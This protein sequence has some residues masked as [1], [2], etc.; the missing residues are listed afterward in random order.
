[1]ELKLYNT[2]TQKKECFKPIDPKHIRIYACG[3][4]VYNFAHIGNARMAIVFDVLTRILNIAY[5]KVSYV[6]NITD[7]DDKIIEKAN[8]TGK[9]IQNITTHYT[10]M[11]NQNMAAL[12]VKAPTHQPKATD[13]IPEM[14][15]FIQKLILA[16]HAYEAEGHVLF[17]V[18]S[19]LHYGQLSGRN[20]DEQ[21][22]GSRVDIAPFKKDPAD[23][24]LWKP[25]TENQPGWPSPWGFGRPGWHTEC[26]AMS[27]SC[28]GFPFDIH[29]GGQD[30]CFPHHENEIAQ[31]CC[32]IDSTQTAKSMA[33]IWIH[34][35]FVT[36]KESKMSKSL[37]NVTLVDEL[38]KKHHGETVRL[39][40]LLSHYRQPLNWTDQSLIQAKSILDR[41]Y[42]AILDMPKN[43]ILT[44]NKVPKACL[45]ALF[46]DINTAKFFAY[47]HELA[48]KI[49]QTKGSEKQ[50]YQGGLL[51]AANLI[52]VLHQEPKVW[53]GY[54]SN[55]KVNE[56]SS[57][58]IEDLIQKRGNAKKQKDYPTADA[59][60]KHLQDLGIELEDSPEGTRWRIL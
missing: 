15:Q 31:S 12:G 37:G 43:L 40:L 57:K 41:F 45:D 44:Q 35:G 26:C 25:S 47:L 13:Y 9:S 48:G 58:E 49:Q 55:L 21:I 54:K 53:L 33:N 36:I 27:L 60:R 28:L 16:D 19:Y 7:I 59:I 39:A 6:S 38:L 3:P 22:A 51:A 52:G 18:P 11:Y 56:I 10:K 20:R 50:H 29:G 2:R 1:M 8:Q 23:F 5:P 14:I 42:R 32:Y 30:L 34:N 4:T 17:H 24:V 46:D